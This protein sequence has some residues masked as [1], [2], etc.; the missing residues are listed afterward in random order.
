MEEQNLKPGEDVLRVA[1]TGGGCSGFS[2][3][4]T[5]IK[6]EEIDSLNDQQY[7]VHGIEYV[8][9]QRSSPLLE[10]VTVDFHDGIDKRG[11]TFDN[12]NA[13]KSCGCGTSFSPY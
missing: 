2:Y 12:P 6:K 11:F 9:D 13:V 4:M 7:E 5:F 1:V 3:G 10:E 8:V